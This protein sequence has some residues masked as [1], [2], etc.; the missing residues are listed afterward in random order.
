MF[1]WEWVCVYVDVCV[2]GE[3]ERKKEEEE[4]GWKTKHFDEETGHHTDERAWNWTP[5]FLQLER[6]VWNIFEKQT[7][8]F[9]NQQQLKR[10]EMNN[11]KTEI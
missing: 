7:N 6:M 2:Y 3:E 1:V 11:F 5:E 9:W 4:T 8:Y 10:K